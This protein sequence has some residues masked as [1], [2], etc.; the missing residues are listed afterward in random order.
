MTAAAAPLIRLAAIAR[1]FGSVRALQ[2][3][4]LDIDA[5]RMLGIVGHNGAGKS[6]LMQIIAGTLPA[7]SGAIAVAGAPIPAYGVRA[8]HALGI[9][10]VF[11]ELS[12]CPNLAVFE[13]VGIM[14]RS[15][16]GAGWRGRA[17]RLIRASLDAIFPGH[18]IDPD[19]QVSSLSI[20]ERQIVEIARAFSETE[21]KVRLVILDEAT[22]SLAGHAATQLLDFTRAARARGIACVFISHRLAEILAYADDIVVLR[23][24]GI[25]GTAPASGLDEDRLV[26]MMG[27]VRAPAGR[28]AGGARSAGVPRVEA[29]G[30]DGESLPLR[31]HAGEI[32]GLAGLAG[33]G[34]RAFLHR[35]FAA[36]RHRERGLAVNGSIAHVSGDRASEGIFPLWSVMRNISAGALGRLSRF[37][38]IDPAAERA[39]AEAWARSLAIRTPSVSHLATHL[40]GG[41]QQKVLVARALASGADI[42]LLDDPTRGV[43]VGTKRELYARMRA[44][45]AGGHAI[46]WYTTENAELAECDRV[47]VF[48]RGRITDAIDRDAYS[49][50]RVIRA[51]FAS[52]PPGGGFAR[53]G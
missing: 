9:R 47:Y 50:D 24:G 42:L 21:E 45:A 4:D 29:A 8:A 49:E 31:V 1:D 26:A 11:Q 6:T 23:D 14:H 16:R 27:E 19:R 2:G 7:S 52:A 40:S 18:G 37:G 48:S 33:H 15:L 17:R 36:A 3:V 5:G 53:A 46:L 10:C 51:S 12:L 25:V 28:D 30:Q 41:N 20:G 38:L 35:V 39:L 43:D 44:H 32:V 22:A 13:N 34:Q